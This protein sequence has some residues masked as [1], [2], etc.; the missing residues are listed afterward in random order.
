MSLAYGVVA[1]YSF[2][3][4]TL[5]MAVSLCQFWGLA[6]LNH[7]RLFFHS[8]VPLIKVEYARFSANF[9]MNTYQLTLLKIQGYLVAELV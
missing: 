3:T 5:G 2:H 7:E 8:Y 9:T 1:P 4:H 6:L